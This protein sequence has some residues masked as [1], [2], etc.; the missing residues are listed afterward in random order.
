MI[1]TDGV[2]IYLA[3]ENTLPSTDDVSVLQRD[4]DLLVATRAA[5]FS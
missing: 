2:N 3:H 1:S 5:G 4:I